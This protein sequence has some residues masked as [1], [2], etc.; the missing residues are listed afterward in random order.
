MLIKEV[1]KKIEL[2][3]GRKKILFTDNTCIISTNF[4]N[5]FSKGKILIIIKK[6]NKPFDMILTKSLGDDFKISD[7]SILFNV[8]DDNGNY[9]FRGITK[10]NFLRFYNIKEIFDY[11][12]G[13][14]SKK[15]L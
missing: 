4:A 14:T 8:Y 9:S 5:F 3:R 11:R 12:G 7:K 1:E 2:S 13:E 15:I 10:S 6:N